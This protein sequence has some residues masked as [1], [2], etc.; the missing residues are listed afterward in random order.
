MCPHVSNGWVHMVRAKHRLRVASATH[1]MDLGPSWSSTALR[2]DVALEHKFVLKHL[3]A[4]AALQCSSQELFV[5]A[6]CF[7]RC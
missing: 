6:C 4:P 1:V 7:C 5:A 2:Y 3:V